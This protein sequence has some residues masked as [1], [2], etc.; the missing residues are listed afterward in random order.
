ML[1]S[2]SEVLSLSI[3]ES[4]IYGLPSLA[5]NN[6]EVNQIEDSIYLQIHQL[7]Y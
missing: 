3:L 5:N 7:R 6:I 4:A 1:L 2:K